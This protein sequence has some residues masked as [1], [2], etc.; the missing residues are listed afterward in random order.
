[1]FTSIMTALSAIFGAPAAIEKL[2]LRVDALEKAYSD[3]QKQKT[4]TDIINTQKEIDA[5]Q[6]DEEFRKASEQNAK[7]MRN[8]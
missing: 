3:L 1:M 6:T 7:N 4:I 8:L 2:M 5:A